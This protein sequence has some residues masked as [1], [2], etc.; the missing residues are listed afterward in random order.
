[1]GKDV[2]FGTQ[3]GYKTI[4]KSKPSE[5]F[6]SI[7]ENVHLHIFLGEFITKD[8]V[9]VTFRI[10]SSEDFGAIFFEYQ[11][12]R[13]ITSIKL[14]L[15]GSKF[16]LFTVTEFFKNVQRRRDVFLNFA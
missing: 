1:M 6:E 16:S 8:E 14:N 15:D 7:Q 2:C 9:N 3:G 10:K 11:P 5:A 13:N 4:F 12:S